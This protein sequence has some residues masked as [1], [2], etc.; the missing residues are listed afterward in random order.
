MPRGCRSS[1]WDWGARR[2]G[3]PEVVAEVALT[4]VE[5]G[6]T[7]AAYAR[8]TLF[9]RRRILMEAWAHYL[10]ARDSQVD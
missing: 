8:S 4:L 3:V 5:K 1:F 6:K 9:V 10:A 2:G 7:V